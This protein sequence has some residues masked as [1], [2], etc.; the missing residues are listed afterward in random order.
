[1]SINVLHLHLQSFIYYFSHWVR[2]VLQTIM[3]IVWWEMR[4]REYVQT[5]ML[6][7]KYLSTCLTLRECLHFP[8]PFP[9]P[10]QSQSPSK[11]NTVSMVTG[12]L[13]GRMYLEAILTVKLPVT[14]STML[15]FD[16]DGNGVRKCK[17]TLTNWVY[18]ICG[19]PLKWHHC[20]SSEWSVITLPIAC[21][22]KISLE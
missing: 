5:N 6:W 12:T 15:N 10:S 3:I 19:I 11:F 14:I 17:H 8:T 1:M 18:R 20:H 16:G 13:M 22:S 4:L 21:Q 2:L 9:S 7:E